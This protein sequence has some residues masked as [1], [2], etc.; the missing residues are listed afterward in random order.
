M[1]GYKQY[2]GLLINKFNMNDCHDLRAIDC[3]L[4]RGGTS[5]GPFFLR[6]ALPQDP[7]S[8][9][10]VLLAALG[11][12]HV[13]QIDGIGGGNT[14]SSKVAIVGPSTDPSADLDYLFAQVSIDQAKVDTRPNCGNMLAAVGPFA[15]ETGLVAPTDPQTAIVIRNVNTGV[16]ADVVVQTPAGRL[17]Y[18]GE[19]QIDGVPGTAAPILIAF[20]GAE[21]ALTGKLLP[22]GNP[23]DTLDGLPV[24]LMD[25]A[26]PVMIIAATQLGLS[27][28]EA[29]DDIDRRIHL[30][31]RLETMR[32]EAGR[33][34]GLGDV[35]DSVVPKVALVSKADNNGPFTS[36]YL[37]P[38]SCHRAHA[39][40]G[41]LCLAMAATRPHTVVSELLGEPQAVP[42][43]LMIAHP[44]GRLGID[45]AAPL[46]NNANALPT[47]SVV[48]TARKL[49]AGQVFVPRR[50]WGASTP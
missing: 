26:V 4:M 22:T 9:D 32:R 33:R 10:A 7:A 28:D 37:T 1:L 2:S 17:I 16:L 21:G 35:A 14:L 23:Q 31:A 27:G 50:I 11:S 13:L 15:I 49:F 44:A 42:G 34:M 48:R 39:V 12:P 20:R 45:L 38:H 6:D 18:A 19:S 8:R 43:T 5:K 29:P 40:T 46:A 25:Y 36:R 41:A 30:L 3:M 24:T 47:L